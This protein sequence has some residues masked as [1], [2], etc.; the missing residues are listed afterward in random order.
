MIFERIK[1]E[2]ELRKAN[3]NLEKY[4]SHSYYSYLFTSQSERCFAEISIPYIDQK[5][6]FA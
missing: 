2:I 5:E 6:K 4:S 1:F 3:T